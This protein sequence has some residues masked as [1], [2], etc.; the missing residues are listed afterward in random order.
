MIFTNQELLDIYYSHTYVLTRN[1][2]RSLVS[3]R[4]IL[5]VAHK[6]K[7]LILEK[8]LNCKINNNFELKEYVSNYL[9]KSLNKKDIFNLLC[10]ILNTKLTLSKNKNGI[11][12]LGDTNGLIEKIL[13]KLNFKY[14]KCIYGNKRRIEILEGSFFVNKSWISIDDYNRAKRKV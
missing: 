1:K 12:S 8:Q 5:N 7:I 11:Y 9:I 6:D 3:H 14:R 4:K 2:Y 10:F 13:Q